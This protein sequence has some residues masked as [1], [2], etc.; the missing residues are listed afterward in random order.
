MLDSFIISRL[1]EEKRKRDEEEATR[2]QPA[3]YIEN[4]ILEERPKTEDK[5]KE[6]IVI[7]L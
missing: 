6:P 5:K 2:E 7:E 3:L 1:L 4:V